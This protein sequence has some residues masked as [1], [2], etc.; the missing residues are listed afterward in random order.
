MARL[1]VTRAYCC[2]PPTMAEPANTDA[3]QTELT[4]LAQQNTE[5]RQQ[6]DAILQEK[7][8][9]S[10]TKKTVLKVGWSVLFPLFDRKRVVRNFMQLFATSSA[11][12]GPR[13]DWPE[14][15]QVVEEAKQFSLALLRFAIRRRT[16]MLLLSLTAFVIPGIQ[17]LLVHKQNQ[18]IETQ[19]KL[20]AVEVYDSVSRGLTTGTST[21]KV[22]VSALLAHGESAV[23]YDLIGEVF[24]DEELS[25]N[26]E[27]TAEETAVRGHLI[28]SLRRYV[29]LQAESNTDADELE[30]RTNREA[31]ELVTRDAFVRIGTLMRNRNGSNA[32]LG[33]ARLY[34]TNLIRLL[35]VQYRL[36]VSAHTTSAYFRTISPLIARMASRAASYGDSTLASSMG[37]VMQGYLVDLSQEVPLE[38]TPPAIGKNVDTVLRDG[39]A[40]LKA[41]VSPHRKTNWNALKSLMEVP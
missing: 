27:D 26:Y 4:R 16:M 38:D 29:Q 31:F 35:Q 33:A 17:I 9:S 14:R 34:V 6:L 7:E 28:R 32:N 22:M 37:I 1:T 39:F 13:A 19:N 10:Q 41:G 24:V 25:I 3:L 2:S 20:F 21:S 40:K 11:F 18:I 23:L 8:R 12:T 30:S 5:L 36:A 15:E